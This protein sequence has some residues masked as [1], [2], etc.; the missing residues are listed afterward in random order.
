MEGGEGNAEEGRV[1]VQV[2][3]QVQVGKEDHSAQLGN[4]G[5]REDREG[6]RFEQKGAEGA[7]SGAILGF[8]GIDCWGEG[9]DSAA[10]R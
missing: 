6:S 9:R 10:E 3:V 8:E 4:G 2:Q 1:Q 5:R 7:K